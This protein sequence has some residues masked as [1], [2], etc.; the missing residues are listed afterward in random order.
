VNEAQVIDTALLSDDVIKEGFTA[1]YESPIS[2]LFVQMVT[3]L[4]VE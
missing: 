1:Q 2:K 3:T 4:Q